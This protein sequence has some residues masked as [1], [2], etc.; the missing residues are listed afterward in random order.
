MFTQFIETF[1]FHQDSKV[2]DIASALEC[3]YI[4]F[5]LLEINP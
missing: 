3:V 2:S 5:F 4:F 1:I